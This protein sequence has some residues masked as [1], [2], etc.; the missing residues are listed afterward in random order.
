MA[1]TIEL[2]D[3][4]VDVIFGME[5]FLQLVDE[6]LGMDARN[7]LEE[8]LEENYIEE[9]EFEKTQAELTEKSDKLAETLYDIELLTETAA[10]Q[11]GDGELA[12]IVDRIKAMAGEALR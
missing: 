10:W 6:Y 2:T 4:R 7:W 9:S 12:E 8:C 11:Q 3:G 1:H 5:D